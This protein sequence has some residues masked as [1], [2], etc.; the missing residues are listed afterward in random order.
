MKNGLFELDEIYTG[1]QNILGEGLEDNSIDLI[2]TDP[3]YPKEF[4]HVYYDM[5][6]YAKRVLKP[7]GS[8]VTLCGHYEVPQVIEALGTLGRLDWHWMGWMVHTG[9]KATLYGFKVV[10]GGKP[11]LW[12][13]KGPISNFYGFWWDTQT[14]E[15]PS[16]KFHKW[17][18]RVDWAW[19]NIKQLCQEG[20]TVL[21]P[22]IGGGTVAVVCKQLRRHFIGFEI[23]PTQTKI[24]RGRLA[25]TPVTDMMPGFDQI[26][27]GVLNNDQETANVEDDIRPTSNMLGGNGDW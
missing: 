22:F 14:G 26:P 7:G 9:P 11:I 8:L 15:G 2:F 18:Q 20:G 5:G 4:L 23:E 13:T 16:K 17:E 3:P 1:D 19:R 10:C 27:I 6:K 24:A 21:D 12:F 25:E